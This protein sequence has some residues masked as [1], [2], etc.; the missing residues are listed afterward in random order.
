M[1]PQ[2]SLYQPLFA[3]INYNRIRATEF[4]GHILGPSLSAD[5]VD[6]VQ[7]LLDM[8]TLVFLYGRLSR[9]T[10]T[11]RLVWPFRAHNK[12]DPPNS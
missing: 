11:R 7:L 4:R 1:Y 2:L 5:R 9:D 8:P 12:N 6:L 10:G 3:A